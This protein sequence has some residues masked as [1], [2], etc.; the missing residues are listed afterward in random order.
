MRK[1]NAI[2]GMAITALF[3]FHAV[4]GSLQLSGIVN[5]G[6]VIMKIA[7]TIMLVGILIHIV[8]GTK[9]TI[10]TVKAMKRSGVSYFRENRLFWIRRIS[11]FALMVFIVSHIIVFAGQT[12][13]GVFRLNL[14]DVPQL[15]SSILLVLTLILHIITNIRPLMIALGADKAKNY[16]GDAA[17][18]LSVLLLLAGAAFVVY[19]IRWIM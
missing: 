4:F 14:F 3:L 13:D 18:V 16:A 9:L 2:L 10:D 1:F 15:I 11:G 6:S 12:R 5:G 8:I 17:I 19:F 7:A